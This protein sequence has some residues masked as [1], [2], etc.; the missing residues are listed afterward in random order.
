MAGLADAERVASS[1]WPKCPGGA[2]HSAPIRRE[3]RRDCGS[4]ATAAWSPRA[5]NRVL[6]PTTNASVHRSGVVVR[7][8]DLGNDM[9][10][11]TVC[12]SGRGIPEAAMASL[13]EPFR[14]R[15]QPGDYAFSGS[16][17]GLSICRKL[18]EA[19]DSELRV[20]TVQGEGT[21]F[22]FTVAVPET[23]EGALL[24]R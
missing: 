21:C 3:G 16:G 12:D 13:F 20:A 8:A 7:I 15:Q 4:V 22:S 17:L 19:M 11:C 9:L 14:R 24:E 10:D 6:L 23:N 5:T 1:P 18:V 2:G